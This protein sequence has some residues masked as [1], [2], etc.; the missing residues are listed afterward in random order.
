MKVR[1]TYNNFEGKKTYF[2]IFGTKIRERGGLSG[3]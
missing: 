1:R 3:N 2:Y